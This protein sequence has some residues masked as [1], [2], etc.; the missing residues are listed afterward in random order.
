MEI[1]G[2]LTRDS[3]TTND[4]PKNSS[5]RR[6]LFLFAAKAFFSPWLVTQD[7]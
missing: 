3:F 4:F 1:P 6:F 7:F 5:F 2:K